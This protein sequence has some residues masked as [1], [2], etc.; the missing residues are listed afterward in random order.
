MNKLFVGYVRVSTEEQGRSG[1][2]LRAQEAAIRDA[3]EREGGTLLHIYCDIQSGKD[4][5][6][7]QMIEAMAHSR[8]RDATLIVSKLDRLSRDAEHAMGLQKQVKRGKLKVRALDTSDFRSTVDVGLRAIL[9]Q[10]E[11]E[12]ISERTKAALAELKAGG[13]R[14]GCPPGVCHIPTDAAVVGRSLGRAMGIANAKERAESYRNLFAS[15]KAQGISTATAMARALNEMGEPSP[16]G[17]SKWQA[18]QVIRTLNRLQ[19]A[20]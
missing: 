7:P 1:L 15:L 20:A 2:G 5:D 13:K 3:V 10:E 17:G 18:V 4:V 8:R 9:A 6:R 12:K 16:R 19:M 14:L 11:R